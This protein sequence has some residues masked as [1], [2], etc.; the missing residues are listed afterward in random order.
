MQDIKLSKRLLKIADYIP[1]NKRIADIGSDHA[2]L[3][4]YLISKEIS[5]FAIAGEINEGPYNSSLKQTMNYNLGKK[6]SVRKGDGLEVIKQG[7][8]IDIIVI[9]GMGGML[10]A[11]IL[12]S[13]KEKL[14][15]VERLILQPNVGEKEVRI[16]LDNNHWSIVD[17]E[18][19]EEDGQIYEIIVAE[20]R[21]DKL[22]PAYQVEFNNLFPRGKEDLYKVGPILYEK[23]PEILIYKW[24][25]ELKKVSYIL[26]QLDKSFDENEKNI[27]KIEFQNDYRWIEEV[28]KCL[29]QD[30]LLYKFSNN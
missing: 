2:L 3:V 5:L 8:E 27:K 18:I 30:N 1:K 14:N 21:V 19:L 17:E 16:W 28:I 6:V 11:N 12:E 15:N 29:Q 9:A 13:G 20:H 10:I 22:D 7:E 4:S 24:K 25:M 26:K 23:K